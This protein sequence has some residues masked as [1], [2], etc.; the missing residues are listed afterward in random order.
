MTWTSDG[1]RVPGGYTRTISRYRSDTTASNGR[2][3]GFALAP[4]SIF[5]AN[6][7]PTYAAFDKTSDVVPDAAIPAN[8]ALA[9]NLGKAAALSVPSDGPDAERIPRAKC[10][11]VKCADSLVAHDFFASG[12]YQTI[13]AHS[14]IARPPALGKRLSAD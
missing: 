4:P 2:P 3:A 1:L 10:P 8:I 5:D 14:R 9:K 11:P 12:F 7:T 13:P 6:A